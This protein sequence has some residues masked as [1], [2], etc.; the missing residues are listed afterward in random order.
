MVWISFKEASAISGKSIEHLKEEVNW[1]FLNISKANS[2]YLTKESLD[3][4]LHGTH[5]RFHE[6]K[7]AQEKRDREMKKLAA[8]QKRAEEARQMDAK[9]QELQS[10]ERQLYSH[11]QTHGTIL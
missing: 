10:L 5:Q 4:Y 11:K 7:F 6:S 1:G 8:D 3:N 9:K 2:D